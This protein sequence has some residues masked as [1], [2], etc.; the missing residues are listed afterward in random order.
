MLSEVVARRFYVPYQVLS[1]T[2]RVK[3]ERHRPV[4]L[5]AFHIILHVLLSGLLIF[6]NLR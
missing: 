2:S 3:M 5:N 4:L 1:S 6:E